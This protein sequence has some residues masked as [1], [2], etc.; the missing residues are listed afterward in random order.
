MGSYRIDNGVVDL[1][2][3]K[4]PVPDTVSA[5]ARI[6]LSSN[7]WGEM[8]D[9]AQPVPM[10]ETREATNQAFAMLNHYALSIW[11]CAVEETTI[12]GVHCHRVRKADAPA[13]LRSKIMINLHGGGFVIGAGALGEAIPIAAQT[14]IEVVAVD[15]RLAPEHP[16]PAAID[17]IVAVYRALLTDHL[18]AD[19]AIFGTSA[20][21]FLTAMTIM[22]LKRD[23]L[24]LPVCCG[25]FTAGGDV[26]TLGD[27]YNYLTLGGFYDHVGAPV[28][29]PISERGVFLR[30]ADRNDPLVAPIKGDLSDFPPT[31]LVSGTRDAILS[32]SALF[33]RALR[34]AGRNAELYVF[35]AMPHAHWYNFQLP[36][37][38]EA[39][40]I[41]SNFFTSHLAG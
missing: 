14:G 13:A 21:G 35:E 24:P 38:R 10:W 30:D 25:V 19:I 28:D 16:F 6:F 8:A 2:A 11:P 29:D 36:E 4:L 23:N 20:G 39:I 17:D 15:Y 32:A 5:E 33:H 22:R 40:D 1:G 34:R 26:A 12:A 9:S 18:P 27:T 7:P 3:V 31:L 41:M 37:T